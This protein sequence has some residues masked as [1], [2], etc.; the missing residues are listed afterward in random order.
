[1]TKILILGASGNI[2]SLVTASLAQA[3]GITLRLTSSR[4]DGVT[5]LRDDY[6]NAQVVKADWRDLPSLQAAFEGIDRVLVITPDFVTDELVATPNLIKAAQGTPGLEQ[7]VRLIAI[8]PNVK[9]EEIT[10]EWLATKTGTATKKI[11]LPLMNASKLPITYVNVAAWIDFNLMWFAG[12]DIQQRRELHLP[13]RLDAPRTWIAEG[14]IAAV[15]EKVLLEGP[16]LHRGKEHILT[17]TEHHDFR[18]VVDMISAEVGETVRLVDSEDGIRRGAGEAADTLLAYLNSERLHAGQVPITDTAE[19][20][21]G[22]KPQSLRDYIA[23]YR[24]FFA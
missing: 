15:I 17:G 14:D 21:L 4:D 23:T 11:T 24:E 2:A 20:M 12:D 16:D 22:R 19:T 18:Q 7:F 13:H 5:R 10:E 1:M 3:R 6:P 8:Y 9:D